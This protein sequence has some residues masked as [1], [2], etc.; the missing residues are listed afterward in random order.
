VHLPVRLRQIH[1][2][3]EWQQQIGL[4][5]RFLDMTLRVG[6]RD[7]TVVIVDQADPQWI[8]A[9]LVLQGYPPVSVEAS[10]VPQVDLR[11]MFSELWAGAGR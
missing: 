3:Y 1:R 11:D 2:I 4:I 6:T 8:T 9:Y 7:G 5:I 10:D